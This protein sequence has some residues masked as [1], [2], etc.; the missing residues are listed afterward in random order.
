MKLKILD[1]SH[2]IDDFCHGSN[3]FVLDLRRSFINEFFDVLTILA[4][5]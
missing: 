2:E 3:N 5:E 1:V 4:D